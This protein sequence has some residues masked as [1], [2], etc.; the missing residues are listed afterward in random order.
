M[1]NR[2]P[3]EPAERWT[4]GPPEPGDPRLEIPEVLRRPVEHP[5]KHPKPAAGT[6]SGLGDLGKALA[7]GLD[8]LF[9]AAAGGV[10]GYFVDRWLGSAPTGLLIGLGI[11]FA[12]GTVRLIQRSTAEDRK[13]AGDGP[14][15]PGRPR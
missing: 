4:G 3:E 5:S 2:A 7:I 11:G 8:F 10:V 15:G 14:R 13:R 12:A 1:E 6:Q 9:T